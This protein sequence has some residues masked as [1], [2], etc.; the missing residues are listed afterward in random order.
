[1]IIHII[2]VLVHV[3]NFFQHTIVCADIVKYIFLFLAFCWWKGQDIGNNFSK[4]YLP[5]I[6]HTMLAPKS[7]GPF[8]WIEM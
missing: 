8:R 6:V 4:K 2:L 7:L 5:G 1:M 3:Y